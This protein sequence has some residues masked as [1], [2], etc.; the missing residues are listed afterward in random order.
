MNLIQC[1]DCEQRISPTA[2]ACIHCGR[3]ATV[4]AAPASA[5]LP[6][7]P[8]AAAELAAADPATPKLFAYRGPGKNELATSTEGI[9]IWLLGPCAGAIL[10]WIW[11]ETFMAS[12]P[13]NVAHFGLLFLAVAVSVPAYFI[14]TRL[15]KFHR[16][17]HQVSIS[18]VN[19]LIGWSLLGWLACVIWASN[20]PQ[21]RQ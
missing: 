21:E 18:V 12:K 7:P 2:P 17:P 20:P 14:P 5:E 15:A 11:A 9:W 4:V 10:M 1:P 6:E 8:C 13:D 16:H 3:P 19:L